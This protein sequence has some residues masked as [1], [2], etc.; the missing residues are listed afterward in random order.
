MLGN[1]NEPIFVS[2]SGVRVRRISDAV[3]RLA[4]AGFRHIELSGGTVFDPRWLDELREL[5]ERFQLQY[6]LHNYFPPPETPFVLN[7]ASRHSEQ[8]SRSTSLIREA[9]ELSQLFGSSRFGF[10]AGFLT[11]VAVEELGQ[12]INVRETPPNDST[13]TRFLELYEVL[14]VEASRRGVRLYV[15]NNV[16]SERNLD[17]FKGKNYLMMCD[18]DEI[19]NAAK[20]NVNILLDLAHLYVSSCSLGRS[21]KEEALCV[22]KKSDYIHLSD[23]D[24]KSDSN[25]ALVA[26]S[27]IVRFIEGEGLGGKTVTLEVYD[28]LPGLEKSLDIIRSIQ[29]NS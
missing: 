5:Q 14:R 23:N 19:T 10:H 1:R 28:D 3:E 9:V 12:V 20:N 8:V 16:L 24:G 29:G 2:T 26:D 25:R 6:R 21:F 18:S 22:W 17:S 27:E 13:V 4:R 15:E 11:D 7:L